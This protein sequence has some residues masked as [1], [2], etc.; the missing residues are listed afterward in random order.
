MEEYKV[1][2]LLILGGF[3]GFLFHRFFVSKEKERSLSELQQQLTVERSIQVKLI[4]EKSTLQAM[5]D[6]ERAYAKEKQEKLSTEFSALSQKICKENSKEF[7]EEAKGKIEELLGP[8]KQK[9]E[10]FQANIQELSKSS[11]MERLTLKNTIGYV[12]DA[13][14][15]LTEETHRL[16]KAL[17][18]DVKKQGAWGELVLQRVLEASG[19][20]EEKE[21]TLQGSGLSLQNT[22]G[23]RLQPDVII[24]LPQDKQIII[25]SKMSYTHYDDYINARTEIERELSL[26][27]LISSIREHI[28]NLSEK[29]YA[30]ASQLET[31]HFVLLFV[32]IEAIFSLVVE[33]EPT[34]FEEA[35][36]KSI[37]LVSP[38]NLLAVL[39][40]VESV[41]KIEKQNRNTQKIAEE[42]A[43][44]YDK[45]V[46]FLRDLEGVS[47]HL[48]ASQ[49]SFDKAFTKLST[50][51]GNIIKRTEELKKLGL[52]T[53]KQIE[54][55]YLEEC[56]IIVSNSIE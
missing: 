4:E 14:K 5:L 24:H 10:L 21:Y 44:L 55:Q 3:C 31:P 38:T 32:P 56:E 36:R 9:M 48:K 29:N 47:K 37:I 54:G 15:A 42:G 30:F 6:L 2:I 7:S 33:A 18:G 50:G 39:R 23:K 51:K 22:E 35:W 41:W 16:A 12:V 27:K 20:R 25:D 28:K 46:D 49:E 43:L 40:T 26:K 19:L 52:K 11:T 8:L 34:L 17:K 13:N 53:K 45:F 1:F